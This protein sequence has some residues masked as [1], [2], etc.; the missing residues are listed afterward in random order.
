M[1]MYCI[2]ISGNKIE[3]N[4]MGGHV[5]RMVGGGERRMQDFGGET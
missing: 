2:K 1:K 5:A 4:D 3:K